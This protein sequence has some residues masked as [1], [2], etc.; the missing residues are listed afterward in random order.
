MTTI[1]LAN[2]AFSGIAL[3]LLA[4]VMRS[5]ARLAAQPEAAPATDPPVELQRAA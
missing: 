1:I 3:A 4:A 2:L 5:P